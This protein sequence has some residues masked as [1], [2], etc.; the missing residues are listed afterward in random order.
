MLIF[1]HLE[2]LFQYFGAILQYFASKISKNANKINQNTLRHGEYV[3]DIGIRGAGLQGLGPGS[4]VVWLTAKRTAK[5]LRAEQELFKEP[6]RRRSKLRVVPTP[7]HA[8][9]LG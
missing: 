1:A 8:R 3:Y 6:S 2:P 4:R 7:T 9:L 5:W